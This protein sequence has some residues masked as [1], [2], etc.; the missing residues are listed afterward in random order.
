[1]RGPGKGKTNN[2]NGRPSGIPNRT[3]K[4]AKELLEKIL[5]GQID[6]INEALDNIRTK[7]SES[8][9]IEAV[10]KLFTYVL[11]KKS[12]TDI[13]TGGEQITINIVKGAKH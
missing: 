4:E 5:F 11:P 10:S 7:E 1:M 6:N 9:Y 2:P 13:T 3:T 8:K 12:E